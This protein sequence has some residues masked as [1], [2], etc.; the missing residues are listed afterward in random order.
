MNGGATSLV[1]CAFLLLLISA[2]G[3]VDRVAM[4]ASSTLLSRA[5]NEMETE[6]NW[7][8]IRSALIGNLKFI[9]GLWYVDPGNE[10]LI[11]ALIKGYA[12]QAFVIDETLYLEDQLQG[13]EQSVHRGDAILNYSR[14]MRYG[15]EFLKVHGLTYQNLMMKMNE[16]KGVFK[17]LEDKM[18]SSNEALQSMLFYAQSLSSLINLQKNRQEMLAQLPVAKAMFDWVCSKKADISFG[19]CDLFYASYEAGRPKMLGGDPARARKIFIDGINRFPHNWLMRAMAVQFYALPMSDEKFYGE[20]KLFLETAAKWHDDE[21]N[22]RPNIDGAPAFAE[23]RLR[24]FQA[25]AIKRF[26]IIKRHEK[27]IF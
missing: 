16:E 27:T 20:Q 5:S 3:T 25:L 6:G 21:M 14:A 11:A 9:E 18:S 24:L 19:A 12:A 22:W 7:E 17:L 2:C 26:E 13:Q 1:I 4:N 23:R 10:E 15:Q 8:N